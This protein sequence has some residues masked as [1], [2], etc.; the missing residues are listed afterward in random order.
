MPRRAAS[1]C[2]ERQ[3]EAGRPP[4]RGP[5]ESNQLA[6]RFRPERNFGLQFLDQHAVGEA[7]VGRDAAGERGVLG[8]TVADGV[9]RDQHYPCGGQRA[10]RTRRTDA[11]EHDGGG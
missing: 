7:E 9:G 1:T 5:E 8:K 11:V 10:G 2:F 6:R 4:E 3:L